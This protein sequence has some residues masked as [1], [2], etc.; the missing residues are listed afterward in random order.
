MDCDR[1]ELSFE[2]ERAFNGS[3]R[4]QA[5][6]GSSRARVPS[7]RFCGLWRVNFTQGVFF[8]FRWLAAGKLQR[9]VFGPAADAELLWFVTS[10]FHPRRF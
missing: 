2:P 6:R 5:V 10:E 3:R 9:K 4:F 1:C 8:N 7:H